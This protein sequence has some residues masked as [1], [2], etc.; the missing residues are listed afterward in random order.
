MI[1]KRTGNR[2]IAYQSNSSMTQADEKNHQQHNHNPN[3]LI[4]GLLVA[5]T[6]SV[7][8]LLIFRALNFL[9]G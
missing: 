6:G 9:S 4:S 7:C 1:I 5:L 3:L 8:W 2:A